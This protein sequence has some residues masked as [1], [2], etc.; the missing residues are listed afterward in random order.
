MYFHTWTLFS[1]VRLVGFWA[2]CF[3]NFWKI[4][5]FSELGSEWNRKLG[6]FCTPFNWTFYQ[7]DICAWCWRKFADHLDSNAKKILQVSNKHIPYE[8]GNHGS[9]I[10]NCM[11]PCEGKN[12]GFKVKYSSSKCQDSKRQLDPIL[13]KLV[14]WDQIHLPR[15]FGVRTN[16]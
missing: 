10:N 7:L 5:L 9:T 6:L 14:L 2:P 16:L 3:F 4:T 15:S 1:F 11:S 12:S 8:S 13:G